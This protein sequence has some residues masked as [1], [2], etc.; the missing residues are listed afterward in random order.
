MNKLK[1]LVLVVSL[2]L[3]NWAWGQTGTDIVAQ[4][5]EAFENEEFVKAAQLSEKA[6]NAGNS[7]ACRKLG[8]LYNEG[9]GVKP[10]PTQAKNLFERACNAGN[11]QSCYDLGIAYTKGEGVRVDLVKAK[12]FF[13]KACNGESA[14][15]CN[16]LAICYEDGLGVKQNKAKAKEFFKKACELDEDKITGAC[17]ALR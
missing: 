5:E 3:T 2:N 4:I 10:N 13:E 6:C 8:I 1:K 11:Y 12:Q 9:I 17:E 15:G 14:L 16:S 7:E